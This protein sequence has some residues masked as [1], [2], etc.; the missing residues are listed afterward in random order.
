MG[1]YT[2]AVELY[3]VKDALSADMAGTLKKLKA[4]GYEAVE[5][6]GDFVHTAAEVR[7]ALD[8][9]GLACCGWHTPVEYLADDRFDATVAYFKT[10]GNENVMIPGLPEEMTGSR[11]AWLQ[12]AALFNRYAARL[13]EHDLRLGYH[14][15]VDE[16]AL[17]TGSRDCP[18]TVFGDNTDASVILQMDN[19]HVLNGR[20]YPM[21]DLIRRY[22]G[23]FLSVHLKPYSLAKGAA[24][25]E[26]GYQTMIGED[27]VPWKDFMALCRSVGGTR[28]YIVEYES[29]LYPEL[30]GVERCL[31]ALRD[32]EKRGEI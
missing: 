10:V 30:E 25:H 16:V 5:F 18:L 22:P 29:P 6:A 8:E 1:Q 31:N 17:Y 12:T 26:A 11:E 7:R 9:A 24:D 19:G 23:R 4:M 32:M 28:W 27:D 21:L 3:S 13:A 20:G 14:N 15:H 2:Y